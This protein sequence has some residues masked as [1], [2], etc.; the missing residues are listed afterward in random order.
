VGANVAGLGAVRALRNAGYEHRLTLV[1]DEPHL[2]YNR[3]PLSKDVLAGTATPESTALL[4][5]ERAELLELDLVLGARATALDLHEQAVEVDGRRLSFDG[6]IIATGTSPRHLEGIER[7]AGVHT[8]RTIEDAVALRDRL[9]ASRKLVIVGAGFIGAE[10]ASTARGRGVEVTIVEL[11]DDPLSS[12][13]GGQIG[14]LCAGLHATHGVELRCGVTL[15]AVEGAGS[16]ERVALSDGSALDADAVV[17]AV[18]VRPN[19]EWLVRSGLELRNGVVCDATLNAGHPAVYAAGDVAR[20]RNE[21]FG[22]EM[23]VEHWTNAEEQGAHAAENLL[24]GADAAKAFHGVNYVWSDQYGL[25]IQ[26]A[27]VAAD[28]VEIVDGSIGERRLLAW[29]RSGET[30]VGAVGIDAPKL[31]AKSRRL[32]KQRATW[33]QALDALA[34]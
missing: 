2:P 31:M 13:F 14:G 10:V 7:P 24:A 29:Y 27:G 21:L 9:A 30:L 28:Q 32:I 22:A 12:A 34:A 17:V 3:P 11:A 16:C 23:R 8:L 33:S 18:G 25:R 15:T 4:S 20:W 19:T 1:G 6:L 5:A 26:F